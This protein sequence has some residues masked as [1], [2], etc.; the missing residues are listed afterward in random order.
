MKIGLVG[1]PNVGKS[2]LFNALTKAKAPAENYPFCTIEPN[3]GVV[4][5]PDER[6][7]NLAK[8]YETLSKVP[9]TIEF[10]DI[11]GLVKNAGKGEGLGNQ[12]L[13][14]IRS[15]D[16]ILEV[17]RCFEDENVVHVDGTVDPATD[18]ETINYELIFS[19]MEL[20]D[21]RIA[22]AQ[23]H[24]THGT[25]ADK[26]L[27]NVLNRAKNDYLMQEKFINLDEFDET[28]RELL[29]AQDLLTTKPILYMANVAEEDLP[30][31]NEHV[32]ELKAYVAKNN[33]SS[34]VIVACAKIEA[35][36][37]ELDDEE[38]KE[39][40]EALGLSESGLDKVIKESYKRLDLITF[41]TAGKKEC[42]AWQIKKGTKAPGAAG[43]IHS[44]FERGFIR[45]EVTK[46]EDLMQ[47]GS[48]VKAK[49]L[50][51]TRV[52]GKEYVVKDG[53]VMFFRFNV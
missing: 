46:Y 16:C 15:V 2:T 30:E 37:A 24:A 17:V 5:V 47:A 22:G 48:D 28:E 32:E 42:R 50:G 21:K 18:A 35:E 14:H 19:D 12:F 49:E 34:S 13:S 7:E 43:K 4:S 31:G 23:K 40:L 20:L 38:R 11:A 3:V 29:L 1:L 10:V 53:D 26:A 51:L 25:P 8:L 27:F 39:Y 45:S 44:D 6:L 52:E 9:T 41:L 36:L 33:A